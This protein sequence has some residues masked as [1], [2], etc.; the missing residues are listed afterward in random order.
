MNPASRAATDMPPEDKN[1]ATFHK[2]HDLNKIWQTEDPRGQDIQWP[3]MLTLHKN[4]FF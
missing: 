3:F 4:H 2:N 1:W